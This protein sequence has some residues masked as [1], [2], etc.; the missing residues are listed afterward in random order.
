MKIWQL[1]LFVSTSRSSY[2]P[3]MLNLAGVDWTGNVCPEGHKCFKCT[4]HRVRYCDNCTECIAVGSSGERC[5]ICRF[6]LCSACVLLPPVN[7]HAVEKALAT[8]VAIIDDDPIID[9][10]EK[11]RCALVPLL[12]SATKDDHVSTSFGQVRRTGE[13]SP[14]F[15]DISLVR[16]LASTTS[17]PALDDRVPVIANDDHAPAH[18]VPLRRNRMKLRKITNSLPENSSLN[19]TSVLSTLSPP[20]ISAHVV[21][22]VTCL[23]SDADPVAS[24]LE[25]QATAVSMVPQVLKKVQL[26]PRADSVS[27]LPQEIIIISSQS[28]QEGA[29]VNTANSNANVSAQLNVPNLSPLEEWGL[30][31][32]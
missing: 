29:V 13:L 22:S 1:T 32:F 3:R 20:D 2:D 30:W 8:D 25:H 27:F 7:W 19:N 28:S 15:S 31:G 12:D 14:L 10:E 26:Q 17:F 16:Q 6:D 23:T 9:N 18:F 24:T 5:K 4:F 21:V 11:T